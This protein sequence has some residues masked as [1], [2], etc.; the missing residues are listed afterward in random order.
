M[1][2][3]EYEWG[4]LGE[5]GLLRRSTAKLLLWAGEMKPDVDCCE[6][7]PLFRVC[8]LQAAERAPFCSSIIRELWVLQLH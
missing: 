5:R 4:P 8:V 3:T 2:V 7:L 1:D 6:S